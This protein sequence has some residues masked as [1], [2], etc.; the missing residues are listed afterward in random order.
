MK[1]IIHLLSFVCLHFL[2][3]ACDPKSTATLPA[4]AKPDSLASENINLITGYSDVNGIKI[5]YEIYG[6][7]KP[8]VLIHGGGSTIQ[9]SF[10]NI[11]PDLAKHHKVIAVEL[12]AHGRTGDRNTPISFEQDA[13]DVA[14]LL[15]NLNIDKADVLGFSNGGNTTM[16]LA[17]R[18][19]LRVD[20]IIVASAFYK[21]SGMLPEFWDFMKKGTIEDMP[22]VLKT[23]F[24]KVNPDSSKL[25]NL[26][27]KCSKR[28]LEFKDWD[29]SLLKSIQA[30]TLIVAGDADVATPEHYV[31]MF[32]LIPHSQLMIIPGGHGKF[33]GEISF[34]NTERNVAAFVPLVEE[35]LQPRVSE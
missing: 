33:M 14:A 31:E 5:Y 11:I 16:Q 30:R 12:Q 24:L 19:P 3:T 32:R 4:E 26:F 7:G 25:Q 23:E 29:D 9:T 18:H 20:N 22:P 28:M 21:R 17:I 13:D 8:L 35:F 10:S 15:K 2:W 27:E 1:K 6:E 34:P